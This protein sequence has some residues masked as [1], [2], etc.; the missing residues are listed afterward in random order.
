MRPT[1][2]IQ[3]PEGGKARPTPNSSAAAHC[4]PAPHHLCLHLPACS[5]PPPPIAAGTFCFYLFGRTNCGNFHGYLSAKSCASGKLAIDLWAVADN[6]N[7]QLFSAKPSS[8]SQLGIVGVSCQAG[9]ASGRCSWASQT[10]FAG[11]ALA[12]AS[13]AAGQH[14]H[15]QHRQDGRGMRRP[16]LR[17]ISLGR[18]V[19]H[20][21][22]WARQ[23]H[24]PRRSA[25]GPGCCARRG[26]HGVYPQRGEMIP[27]AQG[28]GALHTQ[29]NAEGTMLPPT[30][31]PPPHSPH[32]HTR[33]PGAGLLSHAGTRLWSTLSG[34]QLRLP[35][36]G[37]GIVLS[38]RSQSSLEVAAAAGVKKLNVPQ[39]VAALC[40]LERSLR[41]YLWDL[42][43]SVILFLQV[44]ETCTYLR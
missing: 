14:H 24:Q 40:P 8:G 32:A 44:S 36:S 1:F 21:H 3:A 13:V 29:S 7:R 18:P 11:A 38:G 37:D 34:C 5:P 23:R 6:T 39:C 10:N 22:R 12:L 27:W 9:W 19:R 28:A 30:P 4:A 15:H 25:M 35:H 42:Q 26:R 31:T 2:E 43:H 41:Y 33:L 17:R 16:L 20:D